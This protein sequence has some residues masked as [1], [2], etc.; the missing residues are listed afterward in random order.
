LKDLYSILDTTRTATQE[1]LKRS[2]RKLAIQYHPDKNPNNKEAEEKF[3]EVS[4][5]YDILSD[6]DKKTK[7]DNTGSIG[8]NWGNPTYGRPHENWDH[9][10]PNNWG[11][12]D[13]NDIQDDLHGTGFTEMFDRIFGNGK[14]LQKGKDIELELTITLEDSY[15]GMNREIIAIQGYTP[16]NIK[17]PRGVL[18]GQKFIMTGKGYR[19]PFNSN[20]P[21]GN[22]NITINI[23][24]HDIYER[25]NDILYSDIDVPLYS[26]LLDDEIIVDCISG[27]VKIKMNKSLFTK[28]A[29]IKLKGKGMPVYNTLD[30]YGDLIVRLNIVLPEKFDKEQMELLKRI[31]EIGESKLKNI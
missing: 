18:S 31:K 7:Y 27:K 26:A 21:N 16:F 17:I 29:T 3:K 4:S 8:N 24:N 6:P 23:L 28:N 9:R 2:Y 12:F 19:H 14:T 1:E 30:M 22:A 25:N 10:D 15:H 11:G 13:Y 20:L 5:A